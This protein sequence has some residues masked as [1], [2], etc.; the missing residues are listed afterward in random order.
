MSYV[1]VA[2][3]G[4]LAT[5]AEDD[6]FAAS[7][8]NLDVVPLFFAIQSVSQVLLYAEDARDGLVGHW[9]KSHGFDGYASIL[10]L[11][12]DTDDRE[13]RAKMMVEKAR[14]RGDIK[15]AIT[16]NV[17]DA[18]AMVSS[19]LLTFLCARPTY[20]RAEFRPGVERVARSWSELTEEVAIQRSLEERDER[21]RE[22]VSGTRYEG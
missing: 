19:G 8:V 12:D 18:A 2:V 15:L 10:Y 9:L 14:L 5:P 20:T 11:S 16:G 4:V 1:L 3:E 7:K 22:G 6:S 21:I 17:T 13:D